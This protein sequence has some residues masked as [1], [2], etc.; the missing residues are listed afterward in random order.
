MCVPVNHRVTLSVRVESAAI[1]RYRWFTNDNSGVNEVG[2]INSLAIIVKQLC[3]D[4]A[5]L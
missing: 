5:Y 3:A 2:D 1:L 4:D